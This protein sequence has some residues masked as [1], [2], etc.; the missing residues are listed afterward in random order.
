MKNFTLYCCL[1]LLPI[2]S[3][4]QTEQQTI[5]VHAGSNY[6]DPSPTYKATVALS[7]TY[8]SYASEAM[9]LEEMKMHFKTALAAKNISWNALKENPN[10]FGFETLNHAKTGT[11]YEY[12]TSSIEEMK[13]FLTV[14]S[15][16]MQKLISSAVLRIEPS[17]LQKTYKKALEIAHMKAQAI[18]LAMNK[19]LGEIIAVQDN[20]YEG[21]KIE[22][23]I[24]YDRPANEYKYNLEVVYVVK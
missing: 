22:T 3:I 19:Q 14:K 6:T 24:Y 12:T 1:F 5:K 18:A 15:I 21:E 4:A 16:G 20:N 10:E 7:A 8:S 2:L 17:L 11:T 9:S 13:Q 23:S